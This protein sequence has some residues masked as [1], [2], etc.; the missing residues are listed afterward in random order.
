M[1]VGIKNTHIKSKGQ[2]KDKKV[3]QKEFI[4]IPVQ[5]WLQNTLHR[6][7]YW[8]AVDQLYCPDFSIMFTIRSVILKSILH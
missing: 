6:H 8:L 2:C 4:Y 3:S 5:Q 1:T 7:L